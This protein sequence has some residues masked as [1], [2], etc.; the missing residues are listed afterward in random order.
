MKYSQDNA[1]QLQDFLD[2]LVSG[3]ACPGIVASVCD[4]DHTLFIHVAGNQQLVPEKLPMRESTLFDLASV[5]KVV[6]TTMVAARL[7][8]EGLLWYDRPLR[9]YLPKPGNYGDV[10][11]LQ[12]LTH[13]GGFISGKHL[14]EHIKDPAEALDFILG[15]PPIASP[16]SL[17]EY[18]CF[19]FIVLGKILELVCKD[20]LDSIAS[21][22]VF[23]PLKM[24]NTLYNPLASHV[25][26]KTIAATEVNKSSDTV[27]V[28][29]VHD[30]NARFMGGVAGNAGVF[31]TIEDMGKLC[32]MVLRDGASD[33]GKFLSHERIQ[34]FSKDFTPSLGVGRGVG[35]LLGGS[36]GTPAGKNTFGHTG[37]TGTSIWIHPEQKLAAILLTN[38]VH[39]SRD[40][41]LLLPLRKTFH[42]LAFC[43]GA[44][45]HG[46]K[47]KE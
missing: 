6:S 39:P 12:L 9:Y 10:S 38:R 11:I 20:S 22:L 18:S 13:S 3:H 34:E 42:D 31:S 45:S 17:Y 43:L 15:V 47:V 46:E 36:K 2:G 40:N 32:T 8:D 5:S 27:L 41:Q 35:F 21:N 16:G 25:D 44:N 4:P 37:F 7:R 26:R 30:E 1:D 28:G 14:D 29:S 24:N 33:T 19:G 23:S